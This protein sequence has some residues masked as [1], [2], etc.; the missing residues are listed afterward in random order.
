ME[1]KND[2][3]LGTKITSEDEIE[4]LQNRINELE[5]HSSQLRVINKSLYNYSV[6]NFLNSH[7]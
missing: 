3:L 6:S 7:S 2:I 5:R 1:N 4:R